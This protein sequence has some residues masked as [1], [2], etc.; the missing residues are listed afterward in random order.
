MSELRDKLATF[1]EAASDPAAQKM[2]SLDALLAALVE[3]NDPTCYDVAE[4]YEDDEPAAPHTEQTPDDWLAECAENWWVHQHG[5]TD[6]NRSRWALQYAD[7]LIAAAK[8]VKPTVGDVVSAAAYNLACTAWEEAAKERDELRAQLA[9][10]TTERD[11][12]LKDALPWC[13]IQA[14]FARMGEQMKAATSQM[15]PPRPRRVKGPRS[16][17]NELRARIK[18]EARRVGAEWHIGTGIS[19]VILRLDDIEARGYSYCGPEDRFTFRV[20]EPHARRRAY[21]AL[22]SALK[23]RATCIEDELVSE[24][25]AAT[26]WHW[27]RVTP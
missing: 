10:L 18:R 20:G 14:I 22:E 17:P 4:F 6:T 9:A 12:A 21:E 16:R 2:P 19:C 27:E 26:M 25:G 11:E 23:G 24:R 5:S 7:R 3:R 1:R 13:N 15:R 8:E